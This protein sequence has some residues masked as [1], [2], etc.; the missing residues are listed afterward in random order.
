[1]KKEFKFI[2]KTHTYTI[3]DKTLI[4]VTKFI[5]Q[6]FKEFNEKEMAKLMALISKRKG[7]KGQGIRYWKKHWKQMSQHGTR[8]HQALEDFINSGQTPKQEQEDLQKTMAGVSYIVQARKDLG[9]GY[10]YKT[11]V[12]IFDENLGMAGTIDLMIE[13][14]KEIH[15]V[16]WKTNKKIEQQGYKGAKAK[17]PLD[18]LPD[19]NYIKYSLQ[20]NMYRHLL[21][22]K[23]F[24]VK[25]MTLVHLLPDGTYVPYLIPTMKE[26]VEALL[27]DKAKQQ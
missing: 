7:L 13:K 1:M 11:E 21:E 23:G 4:S 25:S 14:G 6:F 9:R 12:K 18:H 17:A 27:N 10:E 5:S 22:Q 8:V 3:G 24:N 16:D 19:C 20:L 2:K 15:L 26:E